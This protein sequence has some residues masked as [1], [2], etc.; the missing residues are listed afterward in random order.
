MA[1][2]PWLVVEQIVDAGL[3]DDS[4]DQGMNELAE[5]TPETRPG[6]TTQTKRGESSNASTDGSSRSSISKCANT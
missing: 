3:R 1:P 6:Q 2:K 4:L 5:Q